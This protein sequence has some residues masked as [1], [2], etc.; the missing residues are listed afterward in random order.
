MTGGYDDDYPEP[1]HR[2]D[3]YEWHPDLP[4]DHF[5]KQHLEN[6]EKAFPELYGRWLN[7]PKVK[8]DLLPYFA[9][10]A[11]TGLLAKSPPTPSSYELAWEIAD[12]MVRIGSRRGSL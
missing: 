8:S 9:A 3:E 10:H 12:E 2:P 5:K 7:K 11:L 1:K 4:I 6:F